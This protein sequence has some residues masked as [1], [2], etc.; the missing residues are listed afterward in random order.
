MNPIRC[1]PAVSAR[2]RPVGS[3]GG[4]SNGDCGGNFLAHLLV[5]RRNVSLGEEMLVDKRL[6]RNPSLV[7]AFCFARTTRCSS[8]FLVCAPGGECFFRA[9]RKLRLAAAQTP[10]RLAFRPTMTSDSTSGRASFRRD[11][12]SGV[13]EFSQRSPRFIKS[14]WEAAFLRVGRARSPA[15][16]RHLDSC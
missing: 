12:S 15:V 4:A 1:F 2:M 9:Q 16:A 14:P 5:R 7:A 10:G 11:D 13:P 6:H 3:Q 8:H